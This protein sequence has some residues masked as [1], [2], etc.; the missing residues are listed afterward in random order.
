MKTKKEKIDA[1]VQWY[2]PVLRI[3]LGGDIELKCPH[4]V[5][6]GGIHGCDGCCSHPSFKKAMK[7]ERKS[8]K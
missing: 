6:H 7:R 8:W 3:N 1:L 2:W 5:G 4:E